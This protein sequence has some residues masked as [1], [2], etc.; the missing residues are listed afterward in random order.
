MLARQLGTT[1]EGASAVGL[2]GHHTGRQKDEKDSIAIVRAA[3]DAGV[4]CRPDSSASAVAWNSGASN[5]TPTA[6][7][8]TVICY[9]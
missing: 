5:L 9:G 2:G 1:G 6:T 7:T 4:N 8:R 3:T